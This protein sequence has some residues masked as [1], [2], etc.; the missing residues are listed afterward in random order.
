MFP[1][2]SCDSVVSV[3][4]IILWPSAA[5]VCVGVLPHTNTHTDWSYRVSL[6]II[7]TSSWLP[8]FENDDYTVIVH[9]CLSQHKVH[10]EKPPLLRNFNKHTWLREDQRFHSKVGRTPLSSQISRRVLPRGTPQH[11]AS[12]VRGVTSC[13]VLTERV[14]SLVNQ[15]QIQQLF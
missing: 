10:R 1:Y 3:P 12:P 6:N 9:R 7:P 11:L 14:V 4:G 5:C 15:R 8:I 13:T 2:L